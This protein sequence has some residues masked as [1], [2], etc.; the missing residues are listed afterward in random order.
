MCRAEQTITLAAILTLLV[1]V[2]T[3]SNATEQRIGALLFTR[4]GTTGC[5][6][7]AEL[8]RGPADP[9]RP[10]TAAELDAFQRDGSVVLKG[11][12]DDRWVRRLRA[13]VIDCFEHPNV[14]DVLYSRLIANFCAQT[15]TGTQP[16]PAC[17]ICR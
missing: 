12:V 9:M 3:S 17:S 4:P 8:G 1:A 10:L 2:L 6:P 5:V 15:P 7:E 14:W 11:V 16:P 13:L